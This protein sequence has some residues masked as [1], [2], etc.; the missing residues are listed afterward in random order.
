MYTSILTSVVNCEQR[1]A[2][3]APFNGESGASMLGELDVSFLVA[4][5]IGAL[6]RG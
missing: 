5:S 6:A 4:Y 3:W 1:G 2:G